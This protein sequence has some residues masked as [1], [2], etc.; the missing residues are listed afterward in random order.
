MPRRSDDDDE[1]DSRRYQIC[2]PWYGEQGGAFTERFAPDFKAGLELQFDKFATLRETLEGT[3]SGGAHGPALPAAT[4]TNADVPLRNEMMRLR[5]IRLRRLCAYIRLHVVDPDI[6]AR[7]DSEA[8]NNG[9]DAWAIVVQHGEKPINGLTKLNQDA[10]WTNL[11]LTDVGVDERTIIKAKGKIHRLDVARETPKTEEEKRLKF[12]SMI[13]FPPTLA[14]KAVDELHR[15]QLTRVEGTGSNRTYVPDYDKTVKAFDELWR[16]AYSQNQIRR[17]AAP[18]RS[19]GG[20]RVD[21]FQLENDDNDDDDYDNDGDDSDANALTRRPFR[22][23]S[24]D[25][26]TGTGVDATSLKGD[27][28]CHNCLGF[29]HMCD[30]CPSIQKDRKI[31]DA[32]AEGEKTADIGGSLGT[33]AF[34]EVVAKRESKSRPEWGIVTFEHLGLNQ[35]DEIVCRC[36]RAGMMLKAPSS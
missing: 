1:Y 24:N 2:R 25:R 36:V 27:I 29:G 11:R 35:R 10:E 4:G 18:E 7:I 5:A 23:G 16:H 13:S 26:R 34:T 33:S 31:S 9:I 14:A 21:A 12:L 32:I 19:R 15:P 20:H 22:R 30:K 8:N 3:D 17:Q 6:Q 28:L